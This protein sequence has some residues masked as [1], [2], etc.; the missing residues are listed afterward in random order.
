MTT[1]KTPKTLSDLQYQDHVL[2][3]NLFAIEAV[4]S[5][6]F[7]KIMDDERDVTVRL[8]FTEDGHKVYEAYTDSGSID[9]LYIIKS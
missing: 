4:A 7:K 2:R 9:Y 5:E 1:F 8:L 3:T 6:Y